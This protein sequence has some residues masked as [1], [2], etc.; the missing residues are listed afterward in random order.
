MSKYLALLA[1]T[2]STASAV[3]KSPIE[4]LPEGARPAAL[5]YDSLLR[6]LRR[7]EALN[8]N[9]QRMGMA[10]TIVARYGEIIDRI[11]Q[12]RLWAQLGDVLVEFEKQIAKLSN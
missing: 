7:I 10:A 6:T 12:E 4:R 2:C 9:P 11:F 5:A 3:R 8:I 1:G